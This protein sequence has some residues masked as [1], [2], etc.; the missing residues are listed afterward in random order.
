MR[1]LKPETSKLVAMQKSSKMG[2][3]DGYTMPYLSLISE[4]TKKD[5]YSNLS[6]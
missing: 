3:E 5:F 6:L 4:Q 1:Q 2:V